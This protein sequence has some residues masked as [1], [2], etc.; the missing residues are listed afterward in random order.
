MAL[1][2]LFYVFFVAM[3]VKIVDNQCTDTTSNVSISLSEHT[4]CPSK[5]VTARCTVKKPADSEDI[6]LVWEYTS[7][8]GMKFECTVLCHQTDVV[9]NFGEVKGVD[10]TCDETEITSEATIYPTC[11]SGV[12][13]FCSNGGM[14]QKVSFSVKDLKMPSLSLMNES[15]TKVDD[16]Y[17]VTV[18]W[19]EDDCTSHDVQYILS[20]SSPEI[21]NYPTN[22][23][24]MNLTLS[25]GIEYTLTVTATLCGKSLASN[26]LSLNFGGP[27]PVMPMPTDSSDSGMYI[28]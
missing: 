18:I 14:E 13:L 7:P 8:D 9:C 16:G 12:N 2:S 10:C 5:P 17:E 27:S 26:K 15:V 3:S 1:R 23:T 19:S 21:M 20:V 24:Q 4:L 6:F 25:E 28:Q 22:L 11:M